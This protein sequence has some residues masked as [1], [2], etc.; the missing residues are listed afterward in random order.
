MVLR[1]KN[2]ARFQHYKHRRPPW[3]RLH[4]ELLDDMTWHSL[5]LASK[6]LA[7]MLWLLA[8]ETQEGLIEGASNVLAFRLRLAS[9]D[10]EEALKPLIASGWIIESDPASILLAPCKQHATSESEFRV[11]S[12]VTQNHTGA[13]RDPAPADSSGPRAVKTA[14]TKGSAS[15]RVADLAAIARARLLRSAQ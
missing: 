15:E 7:P 5:P 13:A 2:W 4:R 3:I 1:V 12:T 8:S 14:T 9:T 10:F 6:A 11:Q